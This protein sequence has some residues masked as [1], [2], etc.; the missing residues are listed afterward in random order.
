MPSVFENKPKKPSP[1]R[2]LTGGSHGIRGFHFQHVY[3][4]LLSIQG[5]LGT[6]S[7]ERIIPEGS[8]DYEIQTSDGLIL[9]QTKS[10]ESECGRD[11]GLD[12]KAI[13]K[14]WRKETRE[15]FKVREYHLVLN[16][17]NRRYKLPS[18][19]KL[20]KQTDLIQHRLKL[21][22]EKKMGMSYV[23]VES[24]PFQKA[25]EILI[26]KKNLL[27]AVANIVCSILTHRIIDL[28][29]KNGSLDI[30]ER[31]GLFVSD[32]EQIVNDVLNVC[33]A[34][35][36]TTLI[37]KGVVREC[38]F[39]PIH[40]DS[41]VHW[42]TDLRLGH[43]TSGFVLPRPDIVKLAVSKLKA[44]GQCIVTG[45]S[46]SGK[47]GLMWEIVNST[48]EKVCWYEV[49]AN[50]DLDAEAL[51]SFVKAVSYKQDVGF[52]VDDI[53]SGKQMA[54]EQLIT[55]TLGNAKVWLLGSVRMED[56]RFISGCKSE[57]ILN[58]K[59][60]SDLAKRIFDQ[61]RD[62]KFTN[63][64]HWREAWES[65]SPHLL[66]YI[67]LLTYEMPLKS[68]VRQQ[69]QARLTDKERIE[70]SREDELEVLKIVLPVLAYGG[71]VDHQTLKN[72][73]H[74]ICISPTEDRYTV[75]YQPSRGLNRSENRLAFALL[76]LVGEFIQLD[77]DNNSELIS[78]QALRSG[79]A[80]EALIELGFLGRKE[81]ASLALRFA[82]INTLEHVTFRIV[83]EEVLSENELVVAVNKR[84][85]QNGENFV[86]WIKLG[87][88]IYRGRL[89]LIVNE[90]YHTKYLKS[91][92]PPTLAVPVAFSTVL[93]DDS[94][95][96]DSRPKSPRLGY[97]SS[98]LA[99]H[100]ALF[101]KVDSITFPNEIL[102]NLFNIFRLHRKRMTPDQIYEVLQL[103]V[104]M[105]IDTSYIEQLKSI[106]LNFE[107]MTTFQ[108]AKIF[109][110]ALEIS[111]EVQTAWFQ[112]C[113]ASKT[114]A[115]LVERLVDES[116]FALP[117]TVTRGN[118]G[119]VAEGNFREGI[120]IDAESDHEEIRR[121]HCHWI[122]ALIPN[123]THVISKIVDT[124]G[125]E[126]PFYPHIELLPGTATLARQNASEVVKNA[127]EA[128]IG[129]KDWVSFLVEEERLISRLFDLC[130][131]HLNRLGEGTFRFDDVAREFI[132]LTDRTGYLVRLDT[133]KAS[134]EIS[135]VME[136]PLEWISTLIGYPIVRRI[137]LL[138]ANADEIISELDGALGS[139][140]KIREQSWKFA[141][142]EPTKMLNKIREY[143]E[144]FRM[145]V[146]ES[147]RSRL[148]PFRQKKN[149]SLNWQNGG[150]AAVSAVSSRDFKTYL[151][152]RE[153]TVR[154]SITS[155]MENVEVLRSAVDSTV[156]YYSRYVLTMSFTSME[157]WT[158]WFSNASSVVGSLTDIFTET[159]DFS[160][161]PI[162]NQKY[163][164]GYRWE[165]RFEKMRNSMVQTDD[166][167][168]LDANRFLHPQDILFEDIDFK[169]QVE[170]LTI[171][172]D[173]V[174]L[175]SV[176]FFIFDMHDGKRK[177]AR[178]FEIYDQ[179]VISLRESY[180]KFRLHL[181]GTNNVALDQFCELIECLLEGQNILANNRTIKDQDKLI[182]GFAEVVW[183]TSKEGIETE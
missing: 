50:A 9:V 27:P 120:M 16:R 114:G 136:S 7:F 106:S 32:I 117:I 6:L 150:F 39:T 170:N 26:V 129:G 71:R 173:F 142:N 103:L 1:P 110:V 77:N 141:S 8:D 151:T 73:F 123:T 99:L 145:I 140:S 30:E 109:D 148:N 122:Q 104:G 76:S 180:L 34:E 116:L 3:G 112:S 154:E 134:R 98:M 44:G 135:F 174:N 22:S 58:Y 68:V 51:T 164:V 178:E 11:I 54:Y 49:T 15:N 156:E 62:T 113:S 81:V 149:I 131:I 153:N 111:N 169:P 171:Y 23:I 12:A 167:D 33:E 65:T 125:N 43:V 5:Y 45:P 91:E 96:A 144:K 19:R 177:L 36:L 57:T 24:N 119:L 92:F 25:C 59:P 147:H 183:R 61:L 67:S 56:M 107:S 70:Q 84:F 55:Y 29:I 172:Q 138:P 115:K 38:N 130:L 126:V 159:E 72:C 4:T 41:N 90:W 66:E 127:I 14:L 80:A 52:V 143:L 10:V 53:G 83:Y 17:A 69:I 182:A 166:L 31:V 168:S 124:D 82:N 128:T 2:E 133:S 87:R 181:V 155:R 176:S 157:D 179:A 42:N 121:K 79:A 105:K 86:D 40:S 28:A 97:G 165:N 146:L 20:V 60:D 89:M 132:K 75:M 175:C 118:D 13:E 21:N 64:V 158:N 95:D 78:V 35:R 162:I 37:R 46:G 160:I 163:A 85:N 88:G 152:E 48:R 18:G 102:F 94:G 100:L 101:N 108:I 63:Q 137:W 139:M 74:E 93:T 161:L 47:S